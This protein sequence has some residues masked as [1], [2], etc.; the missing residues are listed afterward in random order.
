MKWSD[1]LNKVKL[2]TLQ[3]ET[4]RECNLRCKHCYCG[5]PQPIT[6][7]DAILDQIFLNVE[8]VEVVQILGGEPLLHIDILE[9]IV[10]RIISSDWNTTEFSLTT[11]GTIQSKKM[12]DILEKFCCSKTGRAALIRISKDQFRNREKS[13]QTMRYY[14]NLCSGKSN[15]FLE[16]SEIS[17]GL[18]N[19][20]RA[21]HINLSRKKPL[22]LTEPFRFN[23]RILVLNENTIPC[24]LQIS[25]NG[26]LSTSDMVDYTTTDETSLGNILDKSIIEMVLQ[27]NEKALLT[28]S[29]VINHVGQIAMK[30][31]ELSHKGAQILLT[32]LSARIEGTMIKI[33]LR[34]RE[35][36]RQK[37]PFL[38]AQNIIDAIPSKVYI[39]KDILLI[40]ATLKGKMDV[41]KQDISRYVDNDILN[42]YLLLSIVRLS[43][44]VSNLVSQFGH[45]LV[46]VVA[47]GVVAFHGDLLKFLHKGIPS[48]ASPLSPHLDPCL[49]DSMICH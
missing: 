45:L 25:A 38:S 46:D 6:I 1:Y 22:P 14:E 21:T 11:N 4:T 8:D 48:L 37:Y 13:I 39:S 24:G 2:D 34:S 7:S 9:N 29:E 10:N 28:C 16:Y 19:T 32:Q 43:E 15:I 17:S 31:I 3:I 20:G 44:I 35:S 36:L 27:N 12:I 49:V 5:D 42:K 33:S 23:H 41:S 47:V 18:I 26:N 30:G 40:A